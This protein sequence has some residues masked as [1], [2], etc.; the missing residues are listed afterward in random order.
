MTHDPYELPSFLPERNSEWRLRAVCH[1]TDTNA[2]YGRAVSDAKHELCAKCP[3][4]WECFSFAAINDIGTGVWGGLEPTE[5]RSLL[6]V[7][8]WALTPKTR[9]DHEH[10][11]E[12]LRRR[13]RR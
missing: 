6:R 3:V 12:I 2:F 8:A 11:M 4:A 13:K 9:R 10:R 1:D 5:R 7:N